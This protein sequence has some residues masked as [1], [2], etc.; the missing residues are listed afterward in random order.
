MREEGADVGSVFVP[1]LVPVDV[2]GDPVDIAPVAFAAAFG[3]PFL[4]D[5]EL[6]AGGAGDAFDIAL[7]GLQVV[8]I[9]WL[10]PATK[11]LNCGSMTWR[12]RWTSKKMDSASL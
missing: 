9:D 11:R 5:G 8:A 12:R 6:R 3:L 10:E 2:E 1:E 7:E 4:I